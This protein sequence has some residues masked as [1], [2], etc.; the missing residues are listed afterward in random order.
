MTMIVEVSG[1]EVQ[2]DV[3]DGV[4]VTSAIVIV[5]YQGIEDDGIRAGTSWGASPV[6]FAEAAGMLHVTQLDN[7]G[8]IRRAQ[9]AR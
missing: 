3:P 1:K 5:S 7:D 8:Q 9:E 4:I 2:V 6:S